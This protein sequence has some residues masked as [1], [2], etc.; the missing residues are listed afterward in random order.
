MKSRACFYLINLTFSYPIVMVVKYYKYNLLA[1]LPVK[2]LSQR[3]CLKP[4]CY[5]SNRLATV[6]EDFYNKSLFPCKINDKSYD[7]NVLVD[8]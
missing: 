2:F 4:N 6:K 7:G 5:L 1:V 3:R 8:S